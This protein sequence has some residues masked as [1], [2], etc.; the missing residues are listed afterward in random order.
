MEYII[1]GIFMLQQQVGWG[2][3]YFSCYGNNHWWQYAFLSVERTRIVL[4][5]QR[6]WWHSRRPYYNWG[7]VVSNQD[8]FIIKLLVLVSSGWHHVHANYDNSFIN[9]ILLYTAYNKIWI[10]NM[11]YTKPYSYKTAALVVWLHI[12]IY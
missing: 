3:C 2:C 11:I 12:I 9:I 4:V 5:F 8:T 10:I 6:C 7:T 1:A